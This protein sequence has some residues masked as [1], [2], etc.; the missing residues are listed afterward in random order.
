MGNMNIHHAT[1]DR[2]SAARSGV[3]GE[4]AKADRDLQ[5]AFLAAHYAGVRVDL[6]AWIEAHLRATGTSASGFG[7]DLLGDPRFVGSL[8]EGREVRSKIDGLVRRHLADSVRTVPGISDG[9]D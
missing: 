9:S 6:L 7:K 3:A 1:I 2:L 5:D 4:L 8:R